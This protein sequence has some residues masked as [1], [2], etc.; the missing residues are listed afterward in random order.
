MHNPIHIGSFSG[1]IE[2]MQSAYPSLNP[3]RYVI[4]TVYYPIGKFKE[5]GLMLNFISGRD[6]YNYRFVNSGTPDRIRTHFRQKCSWKK[7]T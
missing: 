7:L 4:T 1:K 2:L 6:D 5:F 3:F